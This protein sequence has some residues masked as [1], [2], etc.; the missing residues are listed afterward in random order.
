MGQLVVNTEQC[1]RL[2]VRVTTLLA[3]LPRIIV[4]V[5]F[6]YLYIHYHPLGEIIW[7]NQFGYG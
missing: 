2:I 7:K 6:F 4:A 5:S 3:R 1:S